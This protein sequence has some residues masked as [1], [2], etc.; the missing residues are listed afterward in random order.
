MFTMLTMNETVKLSHNL[1]TYTTVIEP[2]EDGYH[3]YVPILSGCHSFGEMI[4][5]AS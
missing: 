1:G 3:A 4:D 5:K 2:D